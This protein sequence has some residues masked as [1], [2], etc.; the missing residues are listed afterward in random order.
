MLRKLMLAVALMAGCVL[1]AGA[2][3]CT[4]CDEFL[5]AHNNI[6]ANG[7]W[8]PGNPAPNPPLQPLVWSNSLQTLAA[9]WA[10]GCVYGH[11]P[12]RGDTGENIYWQT[13]ST[14]PTPTT[15]VTWWGP[16]EA[17]F[18]N[19]N[20]NT[21]AAGEQCDHYTQIVWDST[22]AVGC[23]IQSCPLGVG[24][25]PPGVTRPWYFVVCNYSPSGNVFGERPYDVLS[26][27]TLS[28]RV[29][30]ASGRGVTYA[31]V[32]LSGGGLPAPQ[33]TRTDRLGNYAFP[34][35]STGQTYTVSVSQ[36]RFNFTPTSRTIALTGN[37]TD[38]NFVGNP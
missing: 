37:V 23:A 28:G 15:A 22:T 13:G 25:P 38:A 6:R 36:P 8:G 5:T 4:L 33:R 20:T 14:P 18:Y 34:N 16:R 7:P 19:W 9:G 31:L 27:A 29:I 3:T 35:L 21:C 17:A 2:Q 11:N 24:T 12:N 32:T 26:T 10:A 30:Q 1:A